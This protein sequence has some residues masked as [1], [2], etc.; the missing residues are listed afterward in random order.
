[1]GHVRYQ[2]LEDQSIQEIH[3]VT[4]H[5]FSIPSY[6]IYAQVDSKTILKNWFQSAQGQFILANSIG[7]PEIKSFRDYLNLNEKYAIVAEL[8]KKKLAEY[9]LKFQRN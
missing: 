4:V 6:D 3:K 9:Y 7:E 8:E 1:M 2:I 5:Q